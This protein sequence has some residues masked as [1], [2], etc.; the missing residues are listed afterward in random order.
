MAVVSR[1]RNNRHGE[2]KFHHMTKLLKG[3]RVFLDTT[4]FSDARFDVGNPAFTKFSE[5]CRQGTFRLF[6]TD[7]TKAEIEKGIE[8][9]TRTL[10]D[11]IRQ[12]SK[13]AVILGRPKSDELKDLSRSLDQ[14]LLSANLRKD[15]TEFFSRCQATALQ[16]PE[17][18]ATHVVRNYILEK[19]P[20]DERKKKAE[21]PDAFVIHTLAEASKRGAG[22]FYI[23]SQDDDFK[24]ACDGQTEL[25]HLDRLSQLLNLAQMDLLTSTQIRRIVRKN[26]AA[27]ETIIQDLLDNVTVTPNFPETSVIERSVKLEDVL[28]ELIIS[29]DGKHAVVDFVCQVEVNAVFEIARAPE[30]TVVVDS[31]TDVQ[32]TNITLEFDYAPKDASVFNVTST[33]SPTNLSL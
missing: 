21:F 3:K 26:F 33:W 12:A 6:T 32:V 5:L 13:L 9:Q 28:D 19:P 14:K 25:V 29:S 2:P 31:R 7:L 17:T 22:V 1:R 30:F 23:I 4:E 10:C 18:S 24:R 27:I 16:I 8:Q 11:I 15:V 20:F